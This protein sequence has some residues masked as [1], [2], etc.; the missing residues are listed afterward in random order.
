MSR[1]RRALV[2]CAHD[3]DEVIGPGGTI[4]KLVKAGVEVST[5]IFAVGNEGYSRLADRDAIVEQ[6]RRERAAAQKILGTARCI[7]WDYHDFDNLDCEGV[8]RKV[9]SAVRAVR[10]HLVFTHLPTDYL[11]HR[12]LGRVVPEAVWQ[13]GWICSLELG[14]PWKADK[15]Y[16]FSVLEPIAKPSHVV[17]VTDAFQD[18]LRAMRA[19]RSQRIVVAGI[20]DQIEAKARMYGSLIGVRYAEAFVRCRHIPVSVADPTVLLNG[21]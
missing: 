2:V 14:K 18:K 21:V 17:D 6:R 9:I 13:S 8:Y 12:T 7:A 10:P 20:L 1:E 19:Y 4:R 15:L 11:A 5:V 3:D 16:Q